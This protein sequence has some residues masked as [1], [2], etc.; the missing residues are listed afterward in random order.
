MGVLNSMKTI[1][2]LKIWSEF[3]DMYIMTAFM[4]SDL[5]GASASSQD[6]LSFSTS[7]SSVEGLEEACLATERLSHCQHGGLAKDVGVLLCWLSNIPGD[8][9]YS[10]PW[11]WERAVSS[12][13][14][15][16][17]VETVPLR[18]SVVSSQSSGRALQFRLRSG[19]F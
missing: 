7:M 9:E 12:D 18:S 13:R 1:M 2:M 8:Q 6:F 17:V 3:P 10:Q 11:A 5:A 14:Y 15:T 4:G 19:I 16:I